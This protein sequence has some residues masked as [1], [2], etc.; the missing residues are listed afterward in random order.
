MNCKDIQAVLI[1]YLDGALSADAAARIKEH[2]ESCAGCRQEA[3]E[4]KVLLTAMQDSGQETP[5]VS[6]RENFQTMLQSEL[7]METMARLLETPAKEEKPRGKVVGF[8]ASTAGRVAAA[9]ILIAVGVGIGMAVR[10]TPAANVVVKADYDS[11]KNVV[12]DMAA[13]MN[14]QK[15]FSL[16]DDESAS[17]RIKAV[18]YTEDI[19]SPDQKVIDALFNSLNKDKNV[20]VRLAALYSLARFADRHTVRDSLVTS[21]GIQSEPII[22]V[23]LI[24]LLAEKREKKAIAPIRDIMTNKK[25]LKEVKDAAQKSLRVL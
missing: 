14:E 8:F 3:E 9:V 10:P 21:L 1:D 15:M 13:K 23:V 11:L 5:P 7:N 24:N 4:M 25:T 17:E 6:L 19:A 12:H 20:N 22:Q 18:S 2:L 16:I